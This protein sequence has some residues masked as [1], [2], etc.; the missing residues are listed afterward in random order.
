[1]AN[2]LKRGLFLFIV[3]I[4][5]FTFLPACTNV[6]LTSPNEKEDITKE[7]GSSSDN[8][9]SNEEFK[10]G[11]DGVIPG[12]IID[13]WSSAIQWN[14][15]IYYINYEDGYKVYRENINSSERALFLD[16]P[17]LKLMAL[18][19][20]I[21]VADQNSSITKIKTDGTGEEKLGKYHS[22]FPYKDSIYYELWDKIYRHNVKTGET[23]EIF[24][25][26]PDE[27]GIHFTATSMN[28]ANDTIYFTALNK[29][30]TLDLNGKHLAELYDFTGWT[31]I[32]DN[33][34]I[35]YLYPNQERA[36]YRMK[37]DG[38][39]ESPEKVFVNKGIISPDSVNIYNGIVYCGVFTDQGTRILKY[40]IEQAK[41]ET[42]WKFPLQESHVIT[43]INIVSDWVYFNHYIPDEGKSALWRIKKDGSSG[44]LVNSEY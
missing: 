40:D 22:V 8:L 6:N 14:D 27:Q 33:G 44:E 29:T 37:A 41:V 35:Y 20:Y 34:W 2:Y 25:K 17:A 36:I 28:I 11:K 32:Y 15:Y 1:M 31:I 39:S 5:I 13:P 18:G 16:I 24:Y 12:N 42:L 9:G 21:I 26:E 19:D 43:D 3:S 10:T 23:E 4:G 30:Y 38:S 7:T